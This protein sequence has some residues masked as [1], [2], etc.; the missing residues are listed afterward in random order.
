MPNP[1]KCPLD[2]L[3]AGERITALGLMSGTSADG[4]DAAAV[5]LWREDEALRL[6]LREFRTV[7]YPQEVRAG[8]FRCFADQ[9][10]VREVCLLN[11]AIGEAFAL[12]A[13]ESAIAVGGAAQIAFVASHGQTVWHEPAGHPLPATLQIGEASRIAERLG[14]PVVSDFRQQDLTLGGQGAPLV[15]YLDYFLF[16]HAQENRAVQNL[17]GIGNVTYLKAGGTLEQVVAFDTGPANALMDRAAELLSGGAL[18]Y[19]EGGALAASAPVDEELLRALLREPYLQAPPPKS[20]GRELFS[21]RRVDELWERGY[22]DGSLIST[23]SQFTVETVS[24]SYRAWLGPVDT[25]I[26]GGGGSRNPELVRRLRVALAP[27]QVK[28]HEDFGLNGE[29]KEAIAFAVMGYETLRGLPSN[30]P[31]ATGARR[32]A[33]LGKICWP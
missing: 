28:L 31:S 9:A 1:S 4:I 25:V 17:G 11:A 18:T 2:R 6:E 13:E 8:L 32:P 3:R 22:R 20:T 23:L 10:T 33:V 26:L 14:V 19:D 27:A 30:V 21:A 29:A 7:G 15:P 24:Q 12:A 5:D 16:A